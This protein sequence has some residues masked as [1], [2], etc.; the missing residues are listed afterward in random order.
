LPLGEVVALTPDG[1]RH[2]QVLRLQPGDPVSLFDGVDRQVRARIERIERK[3]VSARV[4]AVEPT[5]PE[6]PVDAWIAV[7]V[8]ANERMDFL[9]E[10]ATE[11]G[12]AGL[13]PLWSQRSVLRLDGDRAVNRR[14][15]W[16]AIAVAACE[17]CGRGRVPEVR[18]PRDLGDWLRDDGL[19]DDGWRVEGRREDGRAVTRLLLSPGGAATAA[20]QAAR[21]ERAPAPPAARP[22]VVALSGPEGGFTPS[23]R[24]AALAA[25]FVELGLGPRVL[26]ADTAPLAWLAHLGLALE[27]APEAP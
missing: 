6:L 27:G 3:A 19:R 23:E 16:Q 7:V 13:Q 1:A 9:V 10:K 2:V 26:R 5:L 22:A 11:L 8:P 25:G 12:V 21:L 24:Q 14:S 20:D 4:E 18:A 17:Q 15:R